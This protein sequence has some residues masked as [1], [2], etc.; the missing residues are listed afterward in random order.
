MLFNYQSFLPNFDNKFVTFFTNKKKILFFHII[1]TGTYWRNSY[2]KELQ[3]LEIKDTSSTDCTINCWKGETEEDEYEL[4]LLLSDLIKSHNL[5]IGYNSTSFHLPYLKNKYKAYGLLDPLTTIEHIDLLKQSKP[6]ASALSISMKLSDLKLYFHLAEEEPE[7]RTILHTIQFLRYEKFFH[8][9]FTVTSIAKDNDCISLTLDTSVKIT[10]P[11]HLNHE[12]FYLMLDPA[13]CKVMVRLFDGKLRVYYPNY[14][15]Y[16]Y[17]SSEDMIIHK[18]MIS[19]ISK[20]RLQKATYEN[21]YQ[22]ILPPK[23]LSESYITKY[24]TMLF[25]YFIHSPS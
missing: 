12:A 9:D 10:E 4:L 13:S 21:C 7:L 20:D 8:G 25:K 1:T 3:I 17:L 24:L 6:I 2:I 22:M 5:L 18:S 23:E 11:L 19:G 16:Y 14:K 15:E